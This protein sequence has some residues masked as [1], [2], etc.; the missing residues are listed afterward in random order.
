MDKE[1]IMEQLTEEQRDRVERIDE[2]LA[3]PENQERIKGMTSADEIIAFFEEN[4]FS[5]TEEQKQ[6]LRSLSKV[7]AERCEDGELSEEDL[8]A[9]AGGWSWSLFGQGFAIT[10]LGL[11]AAG[12]IPILFGFGPAGLLLI[13]ATALLAGIAFGLSE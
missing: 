5:F 7:V 13:G 2:L 11:L 4:G 6:E 10:G 1:Q 8:E 3:D 12:G 9:I